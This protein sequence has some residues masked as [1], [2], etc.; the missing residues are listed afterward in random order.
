MHFSFYFNYMYYAVIPYSPSNFGYLFGNTYNPKNYNDKTIQNFLILLEWIL[1]KFRTLIN[2]YMYIKWHS[3]IILLYQVFTSSL[4]VP[5]P[6]LSG[7][8]IAFVVYPEAVS[9]LPL[10]QLWA[11]LFFLMLFTVGLDSQV[12]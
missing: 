2:S 3:L 10:P 4:W 12:K 6:S 9:K 1:Q 8:G 7:P 11:V 5:S